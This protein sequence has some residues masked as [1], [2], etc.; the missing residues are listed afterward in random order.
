MTTSRRIHFL[1]RRA[2]SMVEVVVASIIFVIA[3]TGVFATMAKM[4]NP[5]VQSDSRVKAALFGKK[6]LDN[7]S[8][9]VTDLT[10]DTGN[11]SIGTH[12]VA[13]DPADT[14]FAA[15]SATYVVTTHASGARQV[16]LNVQWTPV[17]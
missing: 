5:V 2:F 6:L 3:A 16:T 15:Y 4:N 10:Y 7:L 8:K 13:A 12:M 1:A 11:L 17:P 9:D 14:E